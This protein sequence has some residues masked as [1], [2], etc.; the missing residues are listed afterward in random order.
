MVKLPVFDR[1]RVRHLERALGSDKQKVDTLNN[2]G[3]PS[4][5]LRGTCC[6]P[7]VFFTLQPPTRKVSNRFS[8]ACNGSFLSSRPSNHLDDP[9]IIH[10]SWL[11]GVQAPAH[12]KRR[13]QPRV[14][15]TQVSAARI[16]RPF[17]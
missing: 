15:A 6:D 8:L 16:V 5:R 4:Q 12:Q 9:R 13:L 10:G 11:G 7:E 1:R 17:P 14:K 2:V 3:K